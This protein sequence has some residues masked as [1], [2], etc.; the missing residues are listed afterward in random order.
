MT[1]DEAIELIARRDLQK[2]T[3]QARESLLLNWRDEEDDAGTADE[4]LLLQALKHRYVGVLNEYLQRRL[5]LAER[6]V[7]EVEV[8]RPCACCGF[9]TLDDGGF[10]VCPVCFW[11]ES[12]AAAD[13]VSGVNCLTREQARSNFESIGAVDDWSVDAVLARRPEALREVARL[14]TRASAGRAP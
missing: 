5:G 7:G 13:P 11:E 8:L 9:R 6:V 4:V 12:G 1:R 10:S 14:L 3:P 2:L